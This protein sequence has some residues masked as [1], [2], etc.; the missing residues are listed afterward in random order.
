MRK[1]NLISPDRRRLTEETVRNEPNLAPVGPGHRT[2]NAQ[3]EPNFPRPAAADG[4]NC[5]KRTQLGAGGPRLRISDFGMRIE[6]GRLGTT[7]VDARAGGNRSRG[8]IVQNE[9]NFARR[10]PRGWREN[11]LRRHYKRAKRTQFGPARPRALEARCAKR[12]QSGL[13]GGQMG[14]TNPIWA[15]ACHPCG[16]RGPAAA[17][18]GN[19]L[20]GHTLRRA[21]FGFPP[22]RE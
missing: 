1:T 17:R 20:M 10:T 14:K 13:A 16:G 3:N 12:T 7:G 2:V 5:A 11:A 18:I 15:R 19:V 8:R 22:S 4:G 21:V 9:P 6:R